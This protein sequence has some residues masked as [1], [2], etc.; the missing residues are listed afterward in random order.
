MEIPERGLVDAG[1]LNRL[2]GLAEVLR[3]F[4]S[5]LGIEHF[6]SKMEIDDERQQSLSL[7]YFKLDGSFVGEIDESVERQK[8][9]R[10]LVDVARS[11]QI[12]VIAERVGRVEEI[13]VLR[14]LGVAG[15]T[16][17]AIRL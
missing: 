3:Q 8:F 16:G 5:K 6:G 14:A 15:M 13:E 9:V 11:L 4:D 2:A 12:Q 7:D 10:S 1:G 17:P